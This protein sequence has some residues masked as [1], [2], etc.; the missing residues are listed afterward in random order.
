L[1]DYERFRAWCL[2]HR[3]D[4]EAIVATHVIQTNEVGRCAA[5]LPCLADVAASAGRPLAVL[6]V[7]ASAGLNLLFDRYQYVFADVSVGPSSP[8]VLRPEVSAGRAVSMP[9]VGWRCGLDRKPVDITD[10][11]SV[12]WLR[13]CI[14][15]EQVE[16][17]A[18]FE[19][20]VAIAR[21]DPPRIVQGDAFDGLPDLVRQVPPEF[22]LC[23]MHT[24]VMAYLPDFGRL[25][26][27]IESLA[28]ERP[29]WWL[30]GEPAGLISA[31][32]DTSAPGEG[33]SFLYGVVPFGADG[34]KPRAIARAGTHGAWIEW[35]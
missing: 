17:V 9:A 26:P 24:A 29:I 10:E 5:M 6:E 1:S 32:A 23:V 27:L 7:G 25:G 19:Q 30:S 18:V 21:Q 4:I 20:A 14:W 22:A 28:D 15:P 12:R 3:H 8:V 16:R 11:A 13:S 31:L 33:M 35:L 2:S 34:E